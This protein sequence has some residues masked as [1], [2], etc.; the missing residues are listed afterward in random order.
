[1]AAG[2]VGASVA[3]AW[4]SDPVLCA[5]SSQRPPRV[6]DFIPLRAECAF[7]D[8]RARLVEGALEMPGFAF[9]AEIVR[10]FGFSVTPADAIVSIDTTPRDRITTVSLPARR[11]KDNAPGRDV[12]AVIEVP[13]SP[14][15]LEPVVIASVLEAP[16][17][18]VEG[19]EFNFHSYMSEGGELHHLAVHLILG[20]PFPLEILVPL[21]EFFGV[22]VSAIG[23]D[24][25]RAI[26]T[27]LV[28][29]GCFWGTL[30]VS[31]LWAETG[32]GALTCDF[33]AG[34]LCAL[35]K[36]FP[37]NCTDACKRIGLC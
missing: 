17:R 29:S 3:P 10:G 18:P 6:E 13:T 34:L 35:L 16:L 24:L 1:M 22:D 4:M 30:R 15:L 33:V 31:A 27:I 14:R 2:F 28:A 20:E 12:T 5:I 37:G 7:G 11:E 32:P 9:L 26:W 21:A 25:C 36:E 8:E 19:E 23:C